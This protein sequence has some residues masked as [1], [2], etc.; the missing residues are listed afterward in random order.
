MLSEIYKLG[1]IH[2][3]SDRDRLALTL[4]MKIYENVLIGLHR[5]CIF[6]NLR[7]TITWG[8][9][10]TFTKE[11]VKRFSISVS[12]INA[13]ARSLS[14]GNRQRHILTREPSKRCQS[15]SGL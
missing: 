4:D 13:K 12:D 1:L 8:K 3:P 14:G 2:I 7:I 11:L 5:N 9:V 6:A 10:K 15:Y